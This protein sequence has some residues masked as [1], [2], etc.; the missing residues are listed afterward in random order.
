MHWK[1]VGVL[2]SGDRVYL[3]EETGDWSVE[4]DRKYLVNPTQLEMEEIRLMPEI[5]ERILDRAQAGGGMT[6]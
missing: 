1:C 4:K 5:D 2:K 3:C 6:R